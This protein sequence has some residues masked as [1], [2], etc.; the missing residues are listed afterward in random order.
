ML[1]VL[2]M[3]YK[4]KQITENGQRKRWAEVPIARYKAWF[5]MIIAVGSLYCSAC[6]SNVDK[7]LIPEVEQVNQQG[8]PDWGVVRK[9]EDM[10]IILPTIIKDGVLQHFD[11][12][13]ESS[14]PDG[15]TLCATAENYGETIEQCL[16]SGVFFYR[17]PPHLEGM[18]LDRVSEFDTVLIYYEESSLTGEPRATYGVNKFGKVSLRRYGSV[19]YVLTPSGLEPKPKKP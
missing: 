9:T 3:R 7:T 10:N 13:E 15:V 2:K 18:E 4:M 14:L 6:Q 1:N 19:D 8:R 11:S 17:T 12:R 5:Y 16:K